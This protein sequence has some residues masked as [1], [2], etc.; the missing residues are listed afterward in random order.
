[1]PKIDKVKIQ[2]PDGEAWHREASSRWGAADDLGAVLGVP[3]FEVYDPVPLPDF[4]AQRS[5]YV[6]RDLLG[7]FI[8][9]R[10]TGIVHDCYAAVEACGVDGIRNGTFYHFWSEVG[11]DPATDLPCSLCIP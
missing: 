6:S 9:D 1:M 7:R 11:K 8:Q 4:G 3:A 5:S 10:D 2:D